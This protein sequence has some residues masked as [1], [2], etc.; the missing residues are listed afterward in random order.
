MYPDRLS[1]GT[2]R[3]APL[4][5]ALCVTWNDGAGTVA[6]RYRRITNNSPP[7]PTSY[8][9]SVQRSELPNTGISFVTSVLLS[10]GRLTWNRVSKVVFSLI[11]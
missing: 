1:L 6:V 8:Q 7:R 5:R 4:D 3:G 10:D 9:T 11:C 2:S